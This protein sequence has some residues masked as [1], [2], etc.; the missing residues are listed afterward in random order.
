MRALVFG[1]PPE[2]DEVRPQPEDELEAMLLSMPFG[3]HHVDD[4]RPI[5]PDWVL[6]QPILS[7]I[8][9]SDAKLVMGDF[10]E[11]DLD[12]GRVLLAPP[13]PRP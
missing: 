7:G 10:N 12:N 5:R 4:A 1:A 6:T 9:G 2:E 11:G 8:C 13:H 3:L